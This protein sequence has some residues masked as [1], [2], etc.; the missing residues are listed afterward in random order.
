MADISLITEED[1]ELSRAN[2]LDAISTLTTD[3]IGIPRVYDRR[4]KIL[5]KIII[6]FP[7]EGINVW[8]KGDTPPPDLESTHRPRLRMRSRIF[9]K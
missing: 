8:P 3:Q 5:G 6:R 9:S 4:G 7:A 2:V 1:G